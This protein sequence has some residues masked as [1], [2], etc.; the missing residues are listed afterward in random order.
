MPLQ[1]QT[2]AAYIGNTIESKM[3]SAAAE[4]VATNC[5]KLQQLDP[6][7]PVQVQGSTFS[8]LRGDVLLQ[9]TCQR[10]KYVIR[11]S[12]ECWDKVSVEP[13]GFVD[14]VTKVYSSYATK[15]PCSTTYPLTQR[16][17]G[18]R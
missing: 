12:E 4:E 9:L 5:W 6:A 7:H 10:N 8:I 16:R 13:T 17:D 3:R 14:A 11:E 15:I 2:H 1:A 18:Q